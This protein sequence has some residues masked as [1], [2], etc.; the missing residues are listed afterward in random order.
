[1]AEYLNSLFKYL[2]LLAFVKLVAIITEKHLIECWPT[3]L[4]IANRAFVFAAY[5]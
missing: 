1:M 4:C 2:I 3:S 5:H